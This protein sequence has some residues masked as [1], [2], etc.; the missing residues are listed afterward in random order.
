MAEQVRR[1]G[2]WWHRRDDGVWLRWDESRSRWE[3]Q[4]GEPPPPASGDSAPP[5]APAVSI[6][7]EPIGGISRALM[8]LL[9]VALIIDS[10]AVLSDIGEVRLLTRLQ[11][12]GSVSAAEADSS[13]M[14][15]AAIGLIQTVVFLVTI[16]VWL[17]WFRRA[18]RNLVPFR[19]GELR[20]KPG[21]AVGGWFVP[22]LSLWRPVQITNDIW[23]ASN[24]SVR[25]EDGSAWQRDRSSLLIGL[26]WTAWILANMGGRAIFSSLDAQTI[27]EIRRTAITFLISDSV[28][29]IL[30]ILALLLVRAI[31][32]RQQQKADTLGLTL[33]PV[34]A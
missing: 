7:Y 8:A 27:E 19:A 13:D 29:V 6:P 34:T 31:A 14:R 32:A 22:I 18:Y 1:Q 5:A 24:P 9:L 33:Q 2:A 23:R 4:A 11:E 16:V 30:D 25:P 20:F 10:V 17:I 3:E 28:N 15:Q 21:W 12:G 26:W